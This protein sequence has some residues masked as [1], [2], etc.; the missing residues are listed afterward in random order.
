MKSTIFGILVIALISF[1][2][3]VFG[4]T[5]HVPAD[6]PTIQ[7]GIDV[8]LEGDIVLVA[9]GTYVENISFLG[10]AI[11]VQG[12]QGTESTII[13]GNQSG[14]VV[15]FNNNEGQDSILDGFTL[16]N[17]NGTE[18]PG[19]GP[20]GGGICCFDVSPTVTNCT[21]SGNTIED[22][23]SFGGGIYCRG[24]SLT[25]TNCI[26]T[27]NTV[28][29]MGGGICCWYSTLTMDNCVIANNDVVYY[30]GGVYCSVNSTATITNC[31]IAENDSDLFGGG[32]YNLSSS[33]L[34]SEC[35][36]TGNSTAENG[37]AINNTSSPAEIV[38]CQIS[39]NHAGNGGGI[40]S[41]GSTPTIQ[42]CTIT[43]N[44]GSGIYTHLSVP[45][46]VNSI[47]WENTPVQCSGDV[48]IFFSDIKGGWSGWGNI[49]LDPLFNNPEYDDYHLTPESPCVDTGTDA[50]I[51]TDIDGDARPLG[52]GFDMG[53]DEFLPECWD[54][55]GDGH[56]DIICGGDDCNDDNPLVYPDAPELCNGHDDD[57]DGEIPE[58]EADWDYDEWLV[59]AGDCDD[60]DPLINPGMPEI[61]GTGIDEDCDGYIDESC[62]I[63]ITSL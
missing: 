51:Y 48:D 27:E 45:M 8:A 58:D 1:P 11:T 55:D 25:V 17:G 60:E 23:Y 9:P 41:E 20:S 61:P 53:A 13:D 37:G 3:T 22:I 56:E 34:I 29:N 7:A 46:V 18:A 4:D 32:I 30:G 26:I 49:D 54:N 47:L 35:V 31:M 21:I 6:Q 42:H 63:S 2:C 39:K 50:S 10:K 14:S 43:E 16:Q 52:T 62:F 59:C 44:L 28:Y 24:S 36:F 5:I 12:E 33:I 15:L 38:N 40:Y 57:C 19:Q